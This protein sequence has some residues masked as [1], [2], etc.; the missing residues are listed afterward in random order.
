MD[1]EIRK[2]L[3]S[4]IKAMIGTGKYPEQQI[5]DFAID[6]MI[7]EIEEKKNV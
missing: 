1:Q 4:L 6:K 7:K 3:V 2:E 5:V